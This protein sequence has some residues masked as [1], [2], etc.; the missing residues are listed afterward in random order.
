MEIITLE[1]GLKVFHFNKEAK[2][3]I[4]SYNIV[5]IEDGKKCFI[6]DTAFRRHFKLLHNHLKLHG[7]KITH[8]A[9]THFHRDHIGGIPK[10]RDA[11]IYASDNAEVT[12]KKVFKENDYSQ[13]LP[14]ELVTEKTLQFG[15]FKIDLIK[16]VGHSI[17]G[18]LIIIN[19]KYLYVGDDM[20][21]T[22]DG[23]EL[24]PFASE[25]NIKAHLNSLRRI[26]SYG[27]NKIIIPAHGPILKDKKYI[28]K[29][30]QNR[31]M[32]LKYKFQNPDKNHEDFY[33]ETGIKFLGHEWY[34]NNV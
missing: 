10:I 21:Y 27:E 15:K 30:I 12:L 29:D 4:V 19:D 20:I 24:L 1:E 23:E 22:L 2:G 31:T 8:A 32:Y 14:T 7:K 17:D 5:V 11:K 13:Y 34:K 6:I 3:E 28:I 33:Q 25:G 18:L 9:I 26:Q 16:N